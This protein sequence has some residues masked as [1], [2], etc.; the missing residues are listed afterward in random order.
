MGPSREP[1]RL[2]NACSREKKK[3]KLNDVTHALA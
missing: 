1:I 2:G 3:K